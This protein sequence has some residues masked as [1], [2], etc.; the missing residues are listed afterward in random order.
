MVAQSMHHIAPC[1]N[2]GQ[3]VVR[4]QHVAR[5][6]TP[7]LPSHPSKGISRSIRACKRLATL[8]REGLV[9]VLNAATNKQG[10]CLHRLLAMMEASC[11]EPRGQE[12]ACEAVE[13]AKRHQM[14]RCCTFRSIHWCCLVMYMAS[15][16]H[17]S[18]WISRTCNRRL[19]MSST[20]SAEQQGDR[21][22]RHARTTPLLLPSLPLQAA[23]RHAGAHA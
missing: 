7:H 16:C 2:T 8:V 4:R 20:P 17:C 14:M 3:H 11:S 12:S 18:N 15:S 9:C 19:K 21:W 10:V 22:R 6:Q 5:R 1:F 23:S 13:M